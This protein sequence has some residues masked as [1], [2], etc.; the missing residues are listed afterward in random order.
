M[1]STILVYLAIALAGVVLAIVIFLAVSPLLKDKLL[2]N[3]DHPEKLGMFLQVGTGRSIGID[4]GGNYYY[5]INGDQNGPVSSSA[6]LGL[7]MLY[8]QYI[9]NILHL[10]VYVPFFTEP[11]SYNLPR[12]N[13]KEKDGKRIYEVVGENDPGYRSNHVRTAPFTWNFEFAGVDIQTVPYEVT[14]SAQ[15]MIDKTKVREALYLTESWNVLLDQALNSVTR[16]VV[17]SKVTIDMVIGVIE[18]DLW[19]DSKSEKEIEEDFTV[20]VADLIYKEMMNYKFDETIGGEFAG[21]KL[22]DLGI[23]ILR[24]D[25]TDFEDELTEAE[26]IELRSSVLGRQKGRARDLV[27]QGVANEQKH[28]SNVLAE[29]K[30]ELSDSILK[31]RALVDAVSK[32]GSVET[33]LTALISNLRK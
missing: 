17:R 18:K 23:I 13:V 32:G 5:D 26:R 8:K 20:Q 22:S 11:K 7:W 31:N 9:W 25:I 24:I 33:L 10:H 15:V 21:K 1:L 6:L 29:L 16:S 14:G 30:P 28:I 12:Y 2:H 27:G 3:P 19:S 4:F